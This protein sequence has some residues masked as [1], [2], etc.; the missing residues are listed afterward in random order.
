M[1]KD[2]VKSM[3]TGS[4]MKLIV[5]FFMPLLF[6]MLFQQFYNMMDAMIVGKTLGSKA[7]GAVGGTGA[8]NFMIVG[9]CMGVCNGFAIPVAQKFGAKD[10]TALRKNVANSIWLSIGFSVVTTVVVCIFCKR[11]LIAMDTPTDILEDSYRYIFVIFLGIPVVYLYNLLAGILRSLGDS[12]TPL[13]FLVM[14]SI[15]NIGLDLLAILVLGMGVAGAA[16]ATVISQG[17][18]GVLCLIYIIKKFPIL[19]ISKEEWRPDL[20]CMKGLCMMGIPMG[21]QYSITAIGSVILQTAVNS[22]GSI[23]VSAVAAGNKINMLFACPFDAM[24]STMATYAGQN[25]G[26]KEFDRVTGGIKSCALI[27][28]VYSAVAFVILALFGENLTLLFV[29]AKDT[30]IIR[31]S[32]L[33]LK[34]VSA[35]Y[36]L[37]ALVNIIRFAIQGMG[38]GTLAILA[39]VCEMVARGLIGFV[40]VPKAGYVA[41]CFASPV[42]WIMADAFLIPAY[43]IVL[44]HLK[45]QHLK[46]EFIPQKEV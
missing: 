23:V 4:P 44:N 25:V 32:A 46:V 39:G 16:W 45:R 3:T 13:Y 41:A 40:F 43:F 24:G 19:K 7:L 14:S 28:V 21:L 11:I 1:S 35:F 26:A 42:A 30:E 20:S 5:A 22:L 37:L 10:F 6:G 15:L 2:K 8:I 27:A 29:N 9:F 31:D 34:I 12:K 17:I 33:L 38:Y 36:F 18:S